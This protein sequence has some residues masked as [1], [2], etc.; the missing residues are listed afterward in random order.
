MKT[1][2]ILTRFRGTF[3]FDEKSFLNTLLGFTPYWDYKPNAVH[4]DAPGLYTS[5]KNS[6]LNTFDKVHLKCNVDG[7]FVN[8]SKHP[9]LYIFVLDK[10][11]GYKVFCQPQRIHYNKNKSVLNTITF[12]LE[13]D[14]DEEVIFIEEILTFTLHFIKI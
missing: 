1:K 3:G 9:I 4:A 6:N 13:D 10:P 8:G 5:E 7:S 2:L 14:N 12:Y 11:P